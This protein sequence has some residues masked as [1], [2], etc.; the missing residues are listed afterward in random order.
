MIDLLIK[1][2]GPQFLLLFIFYIALCIFIAW[3]VN[4]NDG[5]KIY[6]LPPITGFDG[7]TIAVLRGDWKTVI[8]TA[9]YGLW[10]R[11]LIDLKSVSHML[12]GTTIEAVHKSNKNASL[13]FIEKTIY[14]FFHKK[15]NLQEIFDDETVKS[16]INSKIEPTIQELQARHLLKKPADIKQNY[17]IVMVTLIAVY[18][19]G[20]I[21]LYFG[22]MRDKPVEFLFLILLMAPFIIFFIL[23]P[24]RPQ[25]AMGIKYLDSLKDKLVW[26]KEK[27]L[28]D[29]LNDIDPVYVAAIFGVAAISSDQYFANVMNRYTG[30]NYGGCGGAGCGGGGCGGG[31]GGCGG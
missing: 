9:L 1:I 10:K 20:A 29:D 21:K 28:Q 11:D 18:I 19:I 26:M 3:K 23:K 17:F 13:N 6:S 30:N 15:R 7:Y 27:A 2:P 4:N 25:T 16:I 12:K 8:E 14:D 5:S 24:A 22:I 31:C